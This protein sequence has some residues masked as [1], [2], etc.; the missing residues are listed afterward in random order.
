MPSGAVVT[1]A[2]RE[3]SDIITVQGGQAACAT[4]VQTAYLAGAFLQTTRAQCLAVMH[5][6]QSAAAYHMLLGALAAYG[7]QRVWALGRGCLGL[8][9]YAVQALHADGAL[10]VQRE[11]ITLV[12]A[13]GLVLTDKLGAMVETAALQQEMPSP[14]AQNMAAI[15]THAPLRAAY[16]ASLAE[17]MKPVRGVKTA[18]LCKNRFLRALLRDA[19][20]AAGHTVDA[21]G[22]VT[23]MVSERSA[24]VMT[25][26][27]APGEEQQ[28]LLRMRAYS[29]R[30]DEAYALTDLDVPEGRYLPPDDSP[31]CAAQRRIEQDGIEQALLLLSLFAQERVE[32]ALQALPPLSNRSAEIPCAPADKGRVLEALCAVAQP[33]AQGGL[34]ARQRDAQAVIRSDP[35]LPLMHV[36]ACA[37]DVEHAQE[38][39]GFFEREIRNLL[40][41]AK[42]E[43]QKKKMHGV[44]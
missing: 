6:G 13:Q 22:E 3:P 30:G 20:T 4:P 34:C 8:L 24:R 33:Q 14:A 27:S 10:L 42:T 25:G 36:S 38:L 40:E 15:S 7:A 41:D 17:R 35:V 16:L 2:M 18:I 39:C 44:I 37:R 9:G 21:G 11:G 32:D 1:D 43:K 28:W 26:I 12:D 19:L 5:D 31:A 23:L 29:A